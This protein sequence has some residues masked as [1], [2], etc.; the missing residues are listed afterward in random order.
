MARVEVD[1]IRVCETV[2]RQG[3]FIDLDFY[4]PVGSFKVRLTAEQA[5]TLRFR[6]ATA[7]IL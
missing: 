7:A 3:D 5:R 1:G 4:L 6:L 2:I